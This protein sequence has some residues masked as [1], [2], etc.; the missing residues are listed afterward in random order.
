MRIRGGF[1]VLS[2]NGGEKLVAR[3]THPITWQTMGTINNVR[4]E[5]T[6]DGV[7]WSFIGTAV[8]TGTYNWTT[9][10]IKSTHVRVRIS[11][12]DDN[13]TMDISDA[14]LSLVYATTVF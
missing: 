1:R 9:P 11:D 14:D 8:N 10:D 2:P 12:V 7:N 4:L 13:T 3:S 5:Y 6:T